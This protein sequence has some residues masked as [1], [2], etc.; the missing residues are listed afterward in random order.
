ML[1]A[2][3]LEIKQLTFLGDIQQYGYV[4]MHTAVAAAA[5]TTTTTTTKIK[6]F[7]ILPL[8]IYSYICMNK[9]NFP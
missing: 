4:C 3:G 8:E 5:A 6:L 1:Y 2:L 7:I 9:M